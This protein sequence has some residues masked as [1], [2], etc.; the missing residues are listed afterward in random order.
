MSNPLLSSYSFCFEF[1]KHPVQLKTVTT[2]FQ[3]MFFSKKGP[4]EK[5][6]CLDTLDTPWIRPGTSQ[7]CFVELCI[8]HTNETVTGS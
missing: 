1:T 5:G 4:K 6:G 2:C 7:N 3:N 8:D